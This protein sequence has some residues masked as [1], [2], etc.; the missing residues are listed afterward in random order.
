MDSYAHIHQSNFQAG[1]VSTGSIMIY[2]AD[3]DTGSNAYLLSQAIA[4]CVEDTFR[5]VD[6]V[7]IKP[8]EVVSFEEKERREFAR[9]S[10]KFGAIPKDDLMPA[11]VVNWPRAPAPVP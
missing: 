6:G 1:H 4:R 10:E 3:G 9:L 7:G 2:I 5:D 11:G 8:I